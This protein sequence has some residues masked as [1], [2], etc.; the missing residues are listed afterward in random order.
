M[1]L[2]AQRVVILGGTSGIG[3]ARTKAP[4]AAA[5]RSPS[6]PAADQRRAG[7][8][9]AAAQGSRAGGPT[10][11]IRP[12]STVCSANLGPI[13]HLAFTAGEP[14]ARTD[15]ATLDL[16]K[17]RG[18]FALRYFGA[19]GPSRRGAGSIPASLRICQ[20]VDG[21]TVMPSPASS[22]WTRR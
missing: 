20:T 17:A 14:L 6:S 13:D 18:F 11:P 1:D 12:W 15:M 16:D 3:L 8:G 5:P 10:S 9:G 21:A 7:T 4:P 2:H 22:P 19:L